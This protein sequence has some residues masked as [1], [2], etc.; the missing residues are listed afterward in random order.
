MSIIAYNGLPGSGK[1]YGVVENVIIP[2]LEAGRTVITNIP[3]RV[4]YLQEDY[5][6]GTVVQFD[7][8]EVMKTP[9]YWDIDKHPMGAVWV[10]DEAWRFWSSG[11][12]AT[13]IPEPEKAFFTEHRHCVGEDGKTTEIVLVTQDNGQMCAF[14]RDLIEETYRA[15]KLSKIGAK[16]KYRVDIYIGGVRGQKP[17]KPMRQMFGSYKPEIY[18]YYSSH[19][20]NKTDFAAGMEE[21]A[22]DRANALKSPLIKYGLP[23]AVLLFIFSGYQAYNWYYSR[24]GNSPLA[25]PAPERQATSIQS[26]GTRQPLKSGD[27]P[28]PYQARYEIQDNWLPESDRYRIVGLVNEVYWIW[29]ETGTRKIHSRLCSKERMTGEPFC[30]IDGKRVTYYSY[31][32]PERDVFAA[33]RNYTQTI[34]DQFN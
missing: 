20:R 12:K 25:E 1:S 11:Q 13:N 9:G 23:F 33:D 30:V 16:N 14:V 29:T 15:E 6:K 4:G 21:K 5:P 28:V 26:V 31:K 7:T 22:D 3:L 10:I 34:G 24:V 32:E 17:G 19:T 8:R 2:A 27:K 18:R